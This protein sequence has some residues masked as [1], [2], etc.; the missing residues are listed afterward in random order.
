M[1]AHP[2]KFMAEGH[3]Y[4]SP[5]VQS[6]LS[7]TFGWFGYG[8]LSTAGSVY[9]F[10]NSMIWAAVPWWAFMIGSLGLMYGA[11]ALDYERALPLK[12]AAFTG[13]TWMMG[14]SILPLVQAFGVATAADAALAT[15][16]SMSSLAGLA[17][18]APSEQF[19]NWGGALSMGCMGMLFVSIAGAF[20]PH[21][22]A[23]YNIWLWGGLAL[24]GGLT[25][26]RTQAIIYQAKNHEKYDPLGNCIGIYLD[27]VNFFIRFMMIM[28]GNRKK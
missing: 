14:L 6:R 17:Y 9:A 23:L 3:T 4:M 7:K 16:L 2:H 26:F 13:F 8:L 27:A 5:I 10:R 20:N 12:A 21:S 19:L 18:Y 28:G 24:T 25:L 1:N 11:H 22:R 15:G